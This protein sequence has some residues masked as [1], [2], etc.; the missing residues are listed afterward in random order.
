MKNNDYG[1]GT[2]IIILHL[3][4]GKNIQIG[5]LGQFRFKKGNYAYVGSAFG[6]GG[7][8]SRIKHHILPKKS[9][10]WHIDY[11]NA[12]IKEVWVSDHGEKVEHEWAKTLGEIASDNTLGFG[13]SDC[14]C[15]SHLFYFESLGFLQNFQKE[16]CKKSHISIADSH[17]LS[18]LKLESLQLPKIFK[19]ANAQLKLR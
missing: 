11:L 8:K 6:P 16:L 19:L 2:Y 18:D 12:L 15:E 13:C 3:N 4:N 14:T 7:L 10:H 9:Y 17:L 5:K 1:R